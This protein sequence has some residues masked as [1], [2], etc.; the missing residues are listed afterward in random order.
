MA[1]VT[2]R[3]DDVQDTAGEQ[4]VLLIEDDDDIA[5]M[6]ATGLSLSGHPAH[7]ASSGHLGLEEVIVARKPP[8]VIVLDLGLPDMPGLEIL[9]NLRGHA[10]PIDVP[11][12]VLSNDTTDFEAAYAHGATE[13]HAKYRTTPR[14]LVDYV[15]AALRR[16]G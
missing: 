3:R 16:A 4:V 11:V 8:S 6:Y 12:I 14:E 13:C 5:T 2:M 7:I 15:E 10:P 1:D 9:D